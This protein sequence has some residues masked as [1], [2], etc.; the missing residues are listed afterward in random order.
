MAS[1]QDIK[2]H[3]E[4]NS[5][6]TV[7]TDIADDRRTEPPAYIGKTENKHNGDWVVIDYGDIIYK[8][9]GIAGSGE[10]SESYNN[11]TN[12]EAIENI[13]NFLFDSN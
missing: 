12:D 3:F 4:Q 11:L 13:D 6:Y 5:E 1:V 8:H 10:R 9:D 7:I 2:S